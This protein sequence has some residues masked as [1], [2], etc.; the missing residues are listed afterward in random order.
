MTTSWTDDSCVNRNQPTIRFPWWIHQ[1]KWHT[2][3]SI[4]PK[5]HKYFMLKHL[6]ELRCYCRNYFSCQIISNTGR[7]NHSQS[8]LSDV[9]TLSFNSYKWINNTSSILSLQYLYPYMG[10]LSSML[11][12]AF[13][14]LKYYPL[15]CLCS[16][17]LDIVTLID[18]AQSSV[19]PRCNLLLLHCWWMGNTV[20]ILFP[21]SHHLSIFHS[22]PPHLHLRRDCDSLTLSQQCWAQLSL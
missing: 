18:G 22:L 7:L 12:T 21:S 1:G 20:L 17:S 8:I 4:M 10:P 15:H 11:H 3:H 14:F 6:T 13:M 2:T 9:T 5:I 19:R 16:L